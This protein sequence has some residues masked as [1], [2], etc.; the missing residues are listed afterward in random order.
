MGEN[1]TLTPP[2]VSYPLFLPSLPPS[3]PPSPSCRWRQSEASCEAAEE[4]WDEEEEAT[5]KFSDDFS[6]LQP[7]DWVD[8]LC[9]HNQV[10]KEGGREGGKE[11]QPLTILFPFLFSF[12]SFFSRC[13]TRPRSSN[14]KAT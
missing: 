12:S 5:L 11:E 7:N 13:G 1:H 4:A 10:R 2:Y 3:L 14:E 6:A 9:Q 8:I